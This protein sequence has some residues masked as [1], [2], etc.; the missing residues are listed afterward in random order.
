[1][2]VVVQQ[3]RRVWREPILGKAGEAEPA[4][5]TTQSTTAATLPADLSGYGV[6]D[7]PLAYHP[8]FT[9]R[10]LPS[11]A[12]DGFGGFEQR[13]LLFESD[14]VIFKGSD[15]ILVHLPLP[16]SIPVATSRPNRKTR[17]ITSA[18]TS[19]PLAL[20]RL[21]RATPMPLPAPVT[22]MTRPSSSPGSGT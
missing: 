15:A 17:P 2:L 22:S 7:D 1:M 18:G 9:V 4:Q 11:L 5:A 14:N 8:S 12:D 10:G 21:T 3:K 16:G 13:D 19:A 20:S 6:F